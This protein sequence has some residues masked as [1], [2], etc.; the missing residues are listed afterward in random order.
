MCSMNYDNCDMKEDER[1]HKQYT[2]LHLELEGRMQGQSIRRQPV[3]RSVAQAARQLVLVLEHYR[4]GNFSR[5]K[6]SQVVK[7]SHYSTRFHLP[8]DS[9]CTIYKFL[10]KHRAQTIPQA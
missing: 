4:G 1:A 3:H 10:Q 8:V 6:K 5:G 9:F 2:R 7:L